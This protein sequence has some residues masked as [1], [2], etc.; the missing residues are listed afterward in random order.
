MNQ[1]IENR[2]RKLET[3]RMVK[4]T[5]LRKT[6]I[7]TAMTP[8]AGDAAIAKLVEEGASPDDMFIRLEPF[9]PEPGFHMFENY[10]W[11]G[12]WVPKDGH[13]EREIARL[14]ALS[15]DQADKPSSAK[16]AVNL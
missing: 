8:E 7:V 15:A 11:E 16:V 2:L 13:D 6:H 3:T 9:E 12:R 10:N 1:S 5:P 4:E 14:R